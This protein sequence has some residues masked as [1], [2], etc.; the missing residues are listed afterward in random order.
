MTTKP[1]ADD[2]SFSLTTIRLWPTCSPE[3]RCKCVSNSRHELHHQIAQSG[4]R[5]AK[6][7]RSK[8]QGTAQEHVNEWS[9]Y[10]REALPLVSTRFLRLANSSPKTARSPAR[11]S[12]DGR[13]MSGKKSGEISR[14]VSAQYPGNGR[15]VATAMPPDGRTDDSQANLPCAGLWPRRK[16]ARQLAICP[17]NSRATARAPAEATPRKQLVEI[18][19]PAFNHDIQKL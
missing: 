3:G 12:R 5:S 8:I 4:S 11:R 13:E 6:N 18:P 9:F 17:R 7:V 16:L 10:T 2:D 1:R 15:T 14:G 19:L